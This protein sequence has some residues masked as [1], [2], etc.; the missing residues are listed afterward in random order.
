MDPMPSVPAVETEQCAPASEDTSAVPTAGQDAEPTRVWKVSVAAGP[1]V[2]TGEAD[3]S[4][5]V[6]LDIM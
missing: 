5:S 1:S 6:C 4:A 3:Q 2:R